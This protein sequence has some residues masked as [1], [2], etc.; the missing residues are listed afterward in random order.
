MNQNN[1]IGLVS[2]N[3]LFWIVVYLVGLGI[4]FTW[5]NLFFSTEEGNYA[6]SFWWGT[7]FNVLIFYGNAFWLYPLKKT[8]KWSG[9]YW[10]LVLFFLI[11]WTIIESTGDYYMAK[12]LGLITEELLT[13]EGERIPSW[14]LIP[15]NALQ[16]FYVHILFFC[17]SFFNVFYI[18]SLKNEELR[19]IL[20]EEQLKSELKYLKAQ[21]NPHFL[22]NGINSVY[23]LIDQKPVIAKDTLLKFSNLLRY[24]LYECNDDLIPLE[25]ELAHIRDYVEMEK[26]RKGDDVVID[27]V[28][29]EDTF[30]TKIPPLLFTPFIE[31]AFKYVSN[32][33]EGIKN[34]I[35]I[36]LRLQAEQGK[37]RFEIENTIDENKLTSNGGIGI[38]NVKKRLALLFPNRHD[39]DIIEEDDRFVVRMTL[40]LT[41]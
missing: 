8:K 23:H 19:R 10:F 26:I 25:K 15:A 41:K 33:D 9:F 38:T 29:P 35:N 21:I 2:A 37:A 5:E 1:I 6:P 7:V 12:K 34:K 40:N 39:L 13:I 31:N 28:M 18:D 11:F 20:V 4:G 36:L 17:L 24:Q 32:H 14:T 3:I 30:Q 27:L 22:F 16:L